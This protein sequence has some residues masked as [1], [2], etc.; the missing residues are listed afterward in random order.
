MYGIR[1]K[2]QVNYKPRRESTAFSQLNAREIPR[3][4]VLALTLHHDTLIKMLM[5]IISAHD[6]CVLYGRTLLIETAL[7]NAVVLSVQNTRG[8]KGLF[9]PPFIKCVFRNK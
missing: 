1:S 8:F 5:D 2:R 9:V 4:V 7:V 6:C 3:V